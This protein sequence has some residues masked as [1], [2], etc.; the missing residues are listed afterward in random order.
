MSPVSPILVCHSAGSAHDDLARRVAR[1]AS[2]IAP[3]VESVTSLPLPAYVEFHLVTRRGWVRGMRKYAERIV[4]E[5]L[6]AYGPDR[7]VLKWLNRTLKADATRWLDIAST[8]HTESGWA[9]VLLCPRGLKH[10]GWHYHP[11]RVVEVIARELCQVAQHH[12][13]SDTLLS[14]VNTSMATRRGVSERALRPVV[15]GHATWC[16]EKVMAE[17]FG[18]HVP[19]GGRRKPPSRRY[20]R[21]ARSAGC[22]QERREADAGNRFVTHVLTGA[23]QRP[24][25][26]VALFNE[27]FRRFTLMPSPAELA[28]PDTWL[29]RVQPV[30]D[31]D[32]S[33]R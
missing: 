8:I 17:R 9:Q 11:S 14:A 2:E 3:L 25:L 4:R 29:D 19:P 7:A 24:A 12:A 20:T 10:A 31:G 1:I 33:A 26:D 18:E 27:V 5:D 22:R 16:A 13:S 21:R 30:W 32:R 28:E 6:A 15:E 23:G